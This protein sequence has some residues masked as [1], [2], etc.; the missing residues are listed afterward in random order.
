MHG[1]IEL[2]KVA[3]Q[4]FRELERFVYHRKP[5]AS[6]AQMIATLVGV[7]AGI[8]PAGV[9]DFLEN[10]ASGVDLVKFRGM[11]A[12]L[13]MQLVTDV[14]ESKEGDGVARF[15][16]LFVAPA[17]GTAGE[18]AAAFAKLHATMDEDGRINELEGWMRS[19]REIGRLL[20]YPESAIEAFVLE[21]SEWA[22][23]GVDG[24]MNTRKRKYTMVGGRNRYYVHSLEHER[25]EFEAHDRPLNQAIEKWTPY[26][27]EKLRADEKKRWLEF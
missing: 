16:M 3:T 20:G 15:V 25:D 13:G 11:L 1:I 12:Q 21:T 10:E 22:K 24:E 5:E 8:K 19:T 6:A 9:V 4:A 27:A 14:G 17:M 26:T 2:M 18:L 23:T 7:Y